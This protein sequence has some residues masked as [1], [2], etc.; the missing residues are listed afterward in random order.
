MKRGLSV[1]RRMFIGGATSAAAALALRAKRKQRKRLIGDGIADDTEALRDLLQDAEATGETA[2][3]H[4]GAY[5]ISGNIK[6]SAD[7]FFSQC[8]FIFTG[9]GFFDLGEATGMIN[10]CDL[11]GPETERGRMLIQFRSPSGAHHEA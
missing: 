2:H 7:V 4:G 1:N 8:D 3:L 11:F 6:S 5:H 9:E 10:N